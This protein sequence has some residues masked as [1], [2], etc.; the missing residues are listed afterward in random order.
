MAA[1]PDVEAALGMADQGTVVA[2]GAL[3]APPSAMSATPGGQDAQA[4]AADG[5]VQP[6]VEASTDASAVALARAL[7]PIAPLP[8]IEYSLP[9]LQV[10]RY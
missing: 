2:S 7:L 3:G 8:A 1:A 10:Q 9:I 4:A 5:H 6:A